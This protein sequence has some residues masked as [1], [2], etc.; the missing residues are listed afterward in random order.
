MCCYITRQILKNMENKV[1]NKVKLQVFPALVLVLA[2]LKLH[3]LV[4]FEP[5]GHC[6]S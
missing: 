4:A 6:L 2:I 5:G 3:F 1:D